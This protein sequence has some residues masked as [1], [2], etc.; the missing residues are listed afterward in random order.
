[1]LNYYSG[2]YNLFA[3]GVPE[4]E[5]QDAQKDPQHVFDSTIIMYFE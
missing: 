3:Q 4:L 2:K 5:P 1:M